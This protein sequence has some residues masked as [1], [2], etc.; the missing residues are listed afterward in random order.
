[1][2]LTMMDDVEDEREREAN[3]AAAEAQA[4]ALSRLRRDYGFLPFVCDADEDMLTDDEE[5]FAF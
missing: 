4:L 3:P 5:A 1:M 2:Q